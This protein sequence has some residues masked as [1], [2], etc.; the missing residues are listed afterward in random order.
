MKAVAALT[1]WP[2]EDERSL[3]DLRMPRPEP[4]PMDLQVA[5]QAV[6]VNPRDYKQRAWVDPSDDSP[7]VLGWDAAGVV[8]AVGPE[9]RLFKP[10]DR[11][12]YAGH[13]NR[14][15]CNSEFHLVDERIAGPM[16]AS[17]SF[18]EAAALPLT[19]LTAWEALFD[20][21]GLS[22]S[23]AP[24]ARGSLLVIGGAGGVGSMAIQLAARVAG[25][26]VIA[27]ASRPASA[28]WCSALGA[29]HVVNHFGD[30]V[31]EVRAAGYPYVDQVLILNQID[32]H[33]PAACE[34]LAPQGSVCSIVEPK[35]ELDMRLLRRKSGRLCWELMFTRPSYATPDM[36]EQHHALRKIAALVDQGVLKTTLAQVLEPINAANFR[37]AYAQLQAMRC[38]GKVVLQGW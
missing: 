30:L 2:P 8:H 4:G 25:L 36:I 6:A 16:P 26:A 19:A 12:Y 33:F 9:V 13:P 22:Q 37:Q 1:C 21:L 35:A 24:S 31:S 15:G 10:G 14:P 29:T 7:R 11:V 27:S 3:C 20:R 23:P 18:A 28:Q 34:L 17:L 38:I 32:R 5:V